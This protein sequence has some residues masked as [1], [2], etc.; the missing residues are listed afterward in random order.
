M[1]AVEV[2]DAMVAA[3]EELETA[4]FTGVAGAFSELDAGQTGG[5]VGALAPEWGGHAL[6]GF[7]DAMG[8]VVGMLVEAFGSI[9]S[10]VAV[11]D[12]LGT[13]VGMIVQMLTPVIDHVLTP[14]FEVFKAIAGFV[15]AALMPTFRALE[16][17]I[18]IV[19]DMFLAFIPILNMFM[20][21]YEAL[22]IA[23]KLLAT[24]LI[25]LATTVQWLFGH[26]RN[27]GI[28]LSNIVSRPLRPGTWGDGTSSPGN[29]GTNIA[30]AVKDLW[31]G[32][33]LPALGTVD[34]PGSDGA[35]AG[36]RYTTGRNITINMEVYTDAIVGENGFRQFSL[37]VRD[38]IYAAE[39]LGA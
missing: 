28:I 39:A 4:I 5:Q 23:V 8:P 35:G 37:M 12:P 24:P 17:V 6:Q 34:M 20:P 3:S 13:I 2:Y 29:L 1:G 11:M 30:N 32:G 19:A 36:A 7:T 21:Y 27:F 14:V 18:R 26:L 31:A 10:V 9:S 15:A 25:V 38:E 33:D 22:G 16:P